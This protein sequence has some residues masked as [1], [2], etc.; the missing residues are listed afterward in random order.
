MV[1]MIDSG[2]G[3]GGGYRDGVMVAMDIIIMIEDISVV[4][5]D[6]RS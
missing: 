4:V 3:D 1:I 5:P 6:S 2:G